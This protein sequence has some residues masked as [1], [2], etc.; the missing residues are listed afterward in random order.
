VS[1]QKSNHFEELSPAS[2]DIHNDFFQMEGES[3][4]ASASEEYLQP[5]KFPSLDENDSE[6][7]LSSD[8]NT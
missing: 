7:E 5:E 4:D 8:N 6:D 3:W 1:K 2:E